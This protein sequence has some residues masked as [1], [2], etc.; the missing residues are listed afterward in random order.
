LGQGRSGCTPPPN[1]P[2]CYARRDA[3]TEA[4]QVAAQGHRLLRMGGPDPEQNAELDRIQAA[5]GACG[6]P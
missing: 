3:L 5:A 2:A 4:A 1:Q 6:D